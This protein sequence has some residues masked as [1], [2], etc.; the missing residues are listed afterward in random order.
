M[1]FMNPSSIGEMVGIQTSQELCLVAEILVTSPERNTRL[2][3]CRRQNGVLALRTINRE[4]IQGLMVGIIQ[5]DGHYDVTNTD[6]SPFVERLLNP[7]LFQFHFTAF[8]GFLFPFA[9][10]FVFLLVGNTVAAMLELNL[11]AKA[12]ALAEI[13]ADGNGYVRDVETSVTGIVLMCFGLTVTADVVAIEIAGK[14]D[15]AVCTE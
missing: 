5:A 6:V 9:A 7:E 3:P 15:F 8:L 11:C 10:F 1:S 4:E 14:T 13:I 12:P 2:M